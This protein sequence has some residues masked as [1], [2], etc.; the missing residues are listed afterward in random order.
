MTLDIGEQSRNVENTRLRLVFPSRSQMPVVFYHTVIHG[1]GFF[2][3]SLVVK[4]KQPLVSSLTIARISLTMF[5]ICAQRKYSKCNEG[6][7]SSGVG[8]IV[9]SEVI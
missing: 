7:G 6:L 2:S 1:L 5:R 4:Y 9:C 3:P 8:T